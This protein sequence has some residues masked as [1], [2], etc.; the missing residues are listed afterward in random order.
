M[1]LSRTLF[2]LLC[3]I[4]YGPTLLAEQQQSILYKLAS[5]EGNVYVINHSPKLPFFI[6]DLPSGFNAAGYGIVKTTSGLFILPQ[7]TGR[8]YQYKRDKGNWQR[9]DSTFFTGYNFG[10]VQFSYKDQI[11]SFG[12]Y[13][14]WQ[15]NGVLR[16]FNELAGEWNAVKT[17]L[18]IPWKMR[19]TGR[20]NFYYVDS[21]SGFLLIGG[22]GKSGFESLKSQEE[23]KI[24]YDLYGLRINVG[25]W[26]KLGQFKDTAYEMIGFLPWGILS[27]HGDIID[28]HANRYYRLNKPALSRL[29]AITYKALQPSDNLVSFCYDSTLY[30]SRDGFRYDSLTITRADLTDLGIAVYQPYNPGVFENLSSP[31]EYGFYILAIVAGFLLGVFFKKKR[32]IQAGKAT[33]GITTSIQS[34]LLPLE[35]SSISQAVADKTETTPPAEKTI[36]FRSSK[37]LELLEEKERVLLEFIYRYSAEERLTTIEEINKVI[38][39]GSRSAEIQKRLRS[40]LIGSINQKMGLLTRDK[41]PVIDKQRSEFDKRSFEYFIRN[42]H[43]ELVERVLGIK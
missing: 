19:H 39:A 38:G 33:E 14:L 26:K 30:L 22:L 16:A 35:T 17:N 8:V 2:I 43:M 36:A 13:G 32:F 6:D 28:L 21:I 41:K 25:E 7:G 29:Q 24:G 42:E 12:G 34:N 11:Y 23:S 40:D 9:V 37:M 18:Y 15:T 4:G 3:I 10:S 27:L 5:L 1:M 20:A 31:V